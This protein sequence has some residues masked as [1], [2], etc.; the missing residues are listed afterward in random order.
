M[1]PDKGEH[2]LYVFVKDMS[3][4]SMTQGLGQEV[5]KFVNAEQTQ[6]KLDIR[7]TQ[8]IDIE[9]ENTKEY[10]K[11]LNINETPIFVL[12]NKKEIVLQSND[13]NK[14]LNYVNEK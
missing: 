6:K 3:L 13:L 11:A 5:L 7:K 12:L 9:V 10:V 14:I 8:F 1:L 4:Q 2:S